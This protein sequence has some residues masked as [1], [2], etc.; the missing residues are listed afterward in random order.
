[1]TAKELA[2]MLSGREYGMEIT[3]E[4]E[5]Q[6]ADAG[7]LVFYGYSDDNV[8]IAGA[9]NDEVGA[10]NGAAIHL[11]K[12]GVLQEPDCDD[13]ESCECPYF[14]AAKKEARTVEAMWHDKGGPCWTFKTDIPHE[15]FHIYEDGELFCVGIVL[16]VEDL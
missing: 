8:E 3:K 4:E 13:F 6:A 10:Y 7:L 15:T 12:T 9:Y 5:R 11:T 16:S 2:N 14:I 1:M